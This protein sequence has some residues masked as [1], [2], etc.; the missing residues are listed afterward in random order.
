MP[1]FDTSGST[2]RTPFGKNQYLRSTKAVK[3]E[4]YTCAAASVTAETIDGDTTQKVLQSGEVVA[5]ITSGG[6]TGKVGPFQ[7]GVLDGRQTAANIVG[8]NDTFLPWQLMHRDVE[9]SVVYDAA[10]VQGWCF[11]RDAAGARIALTNATRD[12]M[13]ALANLA[14]RFS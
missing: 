13:L 3:T 14:L 7:A 4:S 8:V 11:E 1:S 6:D 9:I 2:V 12:A 5:K 10:V